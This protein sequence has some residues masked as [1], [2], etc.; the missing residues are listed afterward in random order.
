MS[1]EPLR[2]VTD[3]RHPVR[4]I[5]N[6]WI[7]L[8]DGCRLAARLW[9]PENAEARPVPAILEYLPYRKRDGTAWRDALT[10]VGADARIVSSS[11]LCAARSA[12]VLVVPSSPCLTIDTRA[13]LEAA[14]SRGQGLIV[15][16]MAGVNDAGCRPIGYGL[17]IGLTR[18]ARSVLRR[19][20]GRS[21]RTH[22][23]RRRDAHA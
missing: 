5:E 19:R 17:V 18:A 1:P 15:T 8:S 10:A 12:R 20:P 23:P 13:A 11:Q 21:P 22:R 2:T 14:G 7:P 3:F 9:L 4:E 6:A 16:T